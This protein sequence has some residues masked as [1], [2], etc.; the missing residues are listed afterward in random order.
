LRL[1]EP[2][3][4]SRE[5]KTI[6]RVD[7]SGVS[8][9]DFTAP[10]IPDL[11]LGGSALRFGELSFDG[12]PLPGLSKLFLSSSDLVTSFSPQIVFL[13]LRVHFTSR[14]G[15]S[16]ISTLRPLSTLW[17]KGPCEYLGPG[18]MHLYFTACVYNFTFKPYSTFHNSLYSSDA[19]QSSRYYI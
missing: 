10:A 9:N 6:F 16:K 11:F 4:S 5:A 17:F 7:R 2:S 18:S 8:L 13:L 14:D 1:Y 15:H 12:V 3:L 19:L